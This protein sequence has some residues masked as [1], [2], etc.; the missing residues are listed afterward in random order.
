MDM[1]QTF[2]GR[3]L[4]ACTGT[5][6]NQVAKAQADADRAIAQACREGVQRLVPELFFGTGAA[7]EAHKGEFCGEVTKLAAGARDPAGF[8]A[9]RARNANPSP[10][11]A[12]CNQD[13]A[14]VTRAACTRAG[15]TRNLEFIASGH[16]DD[17]VRRLGEGGCR[18]RSFT[19]IEQSMRSVC[20]RYAT[21]TRGQG[22]AA[23]QPPVQPVAQPKPADPMQQGLDAVRKLLP[24]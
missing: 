11:F 8:A 13:F 12:A 9:L 22:S 15:E 7:C 2:S 6:Q 3:K 20:S 5:V 23:A 14:A 1:T 17:D 4:G 10:A 16:C 21:I 19:S 18:G 24:F